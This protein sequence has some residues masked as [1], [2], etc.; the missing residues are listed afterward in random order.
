MD[1]KKIAL[2]LLVT[3]LTGLVINNV[4]SEEQV[5][6]QLVPVPIVIN[7]TIEYNI[8]RGA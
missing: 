8:C 3:T 4:I 5:G 7:R 2:V 6:V 1:I